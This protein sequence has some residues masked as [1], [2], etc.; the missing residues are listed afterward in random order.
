MII[1]FKSKASGD[2][3]MFADVAERL[4]LIMDKDKTPQGII[5]VEQLPPSRPCVAPSPK[6]KPGM[7]ASP[8]T[9]CRRTKP[10]PM[11]PAAHT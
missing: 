10:R 1:T 5:T 2:V 8:T 7:P 9:I 6:T 3:I 11:A 4:M